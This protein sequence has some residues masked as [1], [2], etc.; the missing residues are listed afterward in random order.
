MTGKSGC[1]RELERQALEEQ[2]MRVRFLVKSFSSLTWNKQI[3]GSWGCHW[4]ANLSPAFL[5]GHPV[6]KRMTV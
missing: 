5:Q 1:S 3:K 4:A 2:W 6:L